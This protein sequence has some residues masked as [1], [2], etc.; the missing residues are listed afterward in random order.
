[1]HIFYIHSHI[2]YVI[3]QLFIAACNL[4]DDDVRFITSRNYKLRR[5]S[6][7]YDISDFYTYL[8]RHGKLKKIFGIQQKI[9]YLDEDLSTLC[10]KEKFTIY[11]PQF[12]HS[13]FQILAT[14]PL[15][16]NT[17]LMEEGI[18]SYKKDVNLYSIHS[19]NIF[20]FIGRIFCN[21]F[22]LKNNHYNPYPLQKYL[23][24]IC[25]DDE[26]FPYL[27]DKKVLRINTEFIKNYQ[28]VLPDK[29]VVFLPD[30]FKERT[31]ISDEIY[32]DIV[33]MTIKCLTTIPKRIFVKFHP[34][35]GPE[36]RNKTIAHIERLFFFESIMVL[37]DDCI[38]EFEL[39]KNKECIILGM[40]TSLLFYAKKFGHFTVSGLK[41][42]IKN[43]K[44]KK[45][46]NHI[47]DKDQIEQFLSYDG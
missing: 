37:N 41:F 28:A 5:E 1:M 8:E 11:L 16:E 17:V 21:R 23:Y 15:C 2:T 36:I 32:L 20:N 26:C 33:E 34:E 4:K 29:S 6:N 39:I 47:M 45:Y 46:I 42:T 13:I 35:Q 9:K 43:P 12:N 22:I 19:S 31:G 10:N 38:M 30:S 3:A 40:H 27:S 18:T 44:I 7:I 14:H 25:L 24:G